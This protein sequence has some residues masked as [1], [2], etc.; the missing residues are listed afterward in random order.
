MFPFW[1]SLISPRG[2]NHY[3]M[4]L[5]PGGRLRQDDLVDIQGE[6]LKYRPKLWH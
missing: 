4:M 6:I 2:G 1:A 5:N 3:D